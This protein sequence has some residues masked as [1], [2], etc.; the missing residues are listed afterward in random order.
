MELSLSFLH[1]LTAT[2]VDSSFLENQIITSSWCLGNNEVFQ[3]S[4]RMTYYPVKCVCHLLAFYRIVLIIK[5]SA[6]ELSFSYRLQT[7]LT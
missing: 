6:I 1:S 5:K 2:I 7:K 3:E 4:K